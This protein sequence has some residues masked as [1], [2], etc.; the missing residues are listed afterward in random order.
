MSE[1]PIKALKIFPLTFAPLYERGK[2]GKFLLK[3]SMG[4]KNQKYRAPTSKR[5]FNINRLFWPTNLLKL[6]QKEVF[7]Q[8][9]NNIGR[10]LRSLDL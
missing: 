2:R 10:T 4:L 6:L 1:K 8:G 5:N 7:V 3:N 9:L